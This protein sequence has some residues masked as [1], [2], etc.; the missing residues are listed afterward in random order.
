MLK[1]VPFGSDSY[2]FPSPFHED[3]DR[4]SLAWLDAAAVRHTTTGQADVLMTNPVHLLMTPQGYL[5]V[6]PRFCNPLCKR[7]RKGV[8]HSP[9]QT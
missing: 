7:E 6:R 1:A 4:R 3:D 8:L 5:I 2:S 9:G